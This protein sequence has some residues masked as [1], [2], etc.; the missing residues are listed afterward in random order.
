V[1]FK[2]NNKNKNYPQDTPKIKIT[3]NKSNV[4]RPQMKK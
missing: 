2:N 4:S 1:I 3:K